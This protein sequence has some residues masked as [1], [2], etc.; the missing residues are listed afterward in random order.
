[1]AEKYVSLSKLT[2]FLALLKAKIPT[3]TSELSNDSNFVADASYV[4]TDNNYTSTE[5]TKLSKIEGEANKYI[6]PVAKSDTLG[7]VKIGDNI[8]VTSEGVISVE[9][10]EWTNIQDKPTKLSEFTNDSNFI[11]KTVSDLT[12]YY[13]KSNTYTKTEVQSLIGDVKTISIK[14]VSAL[15]STGESNVI[16]LVPA[17]S[18]STSNNYVEYIW[19][20][21]DNK[22]EPIGDTQIDLSNYWNKDNLIEVT[23]A[24]ITAMFNNW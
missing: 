8:S 5:K 6:L 2:D 24:E 17:D 10:L 3:K 18:T 16:Y 14:K 4:H 22:F 19:V 20:A 7:G 15:P 9:S 21:A 23:S 12:N 13:T 11:T 1:M